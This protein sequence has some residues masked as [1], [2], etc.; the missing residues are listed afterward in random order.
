MPDRSVDVEHKQTEK[1]N[2]V[3]IAVK[4]SEIHINLLK[5]NENYRVNLADKNFI[6]RITGD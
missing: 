1:I 2:V 3:K 4:F 5:I 6:S